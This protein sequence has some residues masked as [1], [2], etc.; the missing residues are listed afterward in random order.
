MCG[1][2]ICGELWHARH[3]IAMFRSGATS[4][5]FRLPTERIVPC[6]RG[7]SH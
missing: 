2:Q 3:N 6:V 1:I 4:V 5:D 7:K